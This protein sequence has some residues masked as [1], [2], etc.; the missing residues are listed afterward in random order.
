MIDLVNTPTSTHRLQFEDSEEQHIAESDLRQKSAEE[1]G[2]SSLFHQGA[3]LHD[4]VTYHRHLMTIRHIGVSTS[5]VVSQLG[6]KM[7]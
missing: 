3:P 7:E 5:G 6:K 4:H 2:L 1:S